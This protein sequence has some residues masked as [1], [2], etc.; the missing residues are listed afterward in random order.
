MNFTRIDNA[1][2]TCKTHLDATSARGTEI[3]SY[4]VSCLL[5]VIAAEYEMRLKCM[6]AK[7]AERVNDR[8]VHQYVTGQVGKSVRVPRI[9][10][11]N[12]LLGAFGSD[13]KELFTAAVCNS[14]AHVA[15]DNIVTNRHSVA[16][17]TGAHVTL[18]DLE[19]WLPDSKKVLEEVA[20]A[21]GLSAAEIA[22]L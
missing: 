5:V 14:Q 12:G 13:Y 8:H 18:I 20:L 11:I 16:H 2:A 9:E 17:T 21:L 3:E 22:T 7:R 6:I 19:Q 15:Y 4:L 1:L 10:Q